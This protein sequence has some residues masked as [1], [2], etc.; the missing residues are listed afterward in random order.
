MQTEYYVVA[1]HDYIDEIFSLFRVSGNGKIETL[2][3]KGKD[4]AGK[5]GIPCP[6][7]I[8]KLENG[9]ISTTSTLEG[10]YG[11]IKATESMAKDFMKQ[12]G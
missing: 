8:C 7:E 9:R 4:L 5:L 2:L 6:P 12:G 10:Y 1:C 3:E 11:I